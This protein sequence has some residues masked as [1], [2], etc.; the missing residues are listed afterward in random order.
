MLAKLK[1]QQRNAETLKMKAAFIGGEW[2]GTACEVTSAFVFLRMANKHQGIR[3]PGDCVDFDRAE[4]K[5]VY[6]L[7][8][9]HT[10]NGIPVLLIYTHEA[11]RI[12]N[13]RETMH[14]VAALNSVVQ[15]LGVDVGLNRWLDDEQETR[16]C[17]DADLCRELFVASAPFDQAMNQIVGRR[18]TERLERRFL[19]TFSK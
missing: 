5:K 18:T 7:E 3:P 16:L 8:A 15:I 2:H 14:R 19:E 13:D 6:R 11:T 17:Y 4:S 1:V 10:V 12:T 9:F